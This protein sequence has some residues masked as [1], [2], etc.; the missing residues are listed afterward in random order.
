MALGVLGWRHV[1]LRMCEFV[2][3][4]LRP[5]VACSSACC[6]L[7]MWQS[8]SAAGSPATFVSLGFSDALT[9]HWPPA[10]SAENPL[11]F[12]SPCPQGMPS[13]LHLLS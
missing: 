4:P 2:W 7:S 11:C 10:C 3:Q 12:P 1:P 13:P 9:V 8:L 5:H 6:W